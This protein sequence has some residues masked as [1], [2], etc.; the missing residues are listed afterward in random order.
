MLVLN[1]PATVGLYVLAT[2]IVRVLLERGHF[3]PADTEATAAAVRLYAL[4]LVGYSASRIASPV[5]YA[6]H[7]SA[8]ALTLTLV[9]VVTNVVLGLT[10][11]RVIGFRGLALATSL[12]AIVN[13][14]LALQLLRPQLGGIEGRTLLRTLAKVAAASAVMA[15]VVIA[16][17]DVLAVQWPAAGTAA[18]AL[19]L[20]ATIV[21]GLGALGAAA[22]LL[23]IAEFDEAIHDIRARLQRA[24]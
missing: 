8:I 18:Q 1:V 17:R 5:F 16:V 21:S 6:L 19:Q 23:R 12:A 20:L 15:L 11:T 2:P 3:R 22:R 7:R 9:S 14:A 24:S 13:G 10:L 4:G